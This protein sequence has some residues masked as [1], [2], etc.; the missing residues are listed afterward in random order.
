LLT[1]A[2]IW[3]HRGVLF[4]VVPAL[5]VI[6]W[7]NR[8]L[9]RPRTAALAAAVFASG[10]ALGHFPAIVG[11]YDLDQRLY[12]PVK[13]P[14]SLA[15]VL[16]RVS[17]TVTYDFWM[18]I[19]AET[20]ITALVLGAAIVALLVSAVLHFEPTRV[21]LLA[22]GIVAISF[23]FWIFSTDAHRGAV[24][25]LIIALPILYAFA[26]RELVRL[27]DRG[28]AVASIAVAAAIALALFVPRQ[29]QASAVAA[30]RL[31]QHESWPGGF[32][33]RPAL[34]AI[35][36]RFV[37]CYADMWVAHKL[38]WLSEPTVRFIPYRSVNRRMV[39]SLRLGAV[40]GPK[41]FVDL[42]GEVHPLDARQETALRVETLWHMHGWPRRA[43]PVPWSSLK[44]RAPWRN[45]TPSSVRSTR[46]STASPASTTWSASA[47][48]PGA[49][50]RRRPPPTHAPSSS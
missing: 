6:V 49:Y 43:P 14:W 48:S 8:E 35:E 25:Y 39:D 22:A 3:I 31:E 16:T 42:A 32:D 26:A 19:G 18:L 24:R 9:L 30:A 23:A 7:S 10:T 50:T 44:L 28:R 38:E 47:G 1:G 11:R 5:A 17:D 27:F 13:P 4:V 20:A 29:Q 21:T 45:S 15:H 36:G 37:V 34:G 2:G 41:C 12:L 40:P 33:P 46:T